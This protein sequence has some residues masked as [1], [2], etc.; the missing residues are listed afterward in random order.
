MDELKNLHLTEQSFRFNPQQLLASSVGLHPASQTG[1]AIVMRGAKSPIVE[2]TE[3]TPDDLPEQV[4]E[5]FACQATQQ[6]EWRP[7]PPRF[8]NAR[9]GDVV[10]APTSPTLIGE[11]LRALDPP[12]LHAH[13][14]IMTA[15]YT[16]VT[17]STAAPDRLLDYPQGS[18][19]GQPAP[20][21]GH[22]PDVL[23]YLWPGVI[24]QD[25]QTSIDGQ[26]LFDPEKPEKSYVIGGF[27][28]NQTKVDLGTLP[29]F[30]QP[31]VV[32][33]DPALETP[34]VRAK[35]HQAAD[36]AL[37]QTGKSHYRFY[38]YSNAAI[39]LT[40]KAPNSAGW[41]E[42]TFPSVCSSLVWMAIAKTGAK[43]EGAALESS[44]LATKPVRAIG[45]HDGLYV[46]R[47]EE[48]LVAGEL[49]YNLLYQMVIEK[50]LDSGAGALGGMLAD[51]AD[52]VANQILNTFASDHAETASKDS[53]AWRQ[54]QDASA[55]SPDN[56]LHWDGP[57]KQGLFGYFEPL[58]Y[59][60][61]RLELVTVHK[62]KKVATRGSISG[63]VTFNS[64]PVDKATVQVSEIKAT[65]T[66]PDGR[67]TLA[68]V[69][70]GDYLLKA[71]KPQPNGLYLSAQKNT[72]VIAGKTTT[73]N[74]QLTGPSDLYRQA[75]ID[76]TMA[77]MDYEWNAAAYPRS[78]EEFYR[79][80]RVGPYGTH[81]ET[82]VGDHADDV[83]GVAI[84]KAD[85]NPD[86][87]IKITLIGRY[88]DGSDEAGDL[89][90]ESKPHTF[91]VPA[92]ATVGKHLLIVDGALE[93]KYSADHV[94]IS[95]L[96]KNTRHPLRPS[97]H[98]PTGPWALNALLS[99]ASASGSRLP[100]LVPRH[101]GGKPD[102]ISL[103]RETA[104]TRR[105]GNRMPK[106]RKPK[107]EKAA[108]SNIPSATQV[109]P[110]QIEIN[111]PPIMSLLTWRS[112]L[113]DANKPG[114]AVVRPDDL[115]AL[116]IEVVNLAVVPGQPPLL[117]RASTGP[118]YIVLHFP[119][120]SIAEE[121]F[122]LTAPPS[123]GPP[124]VPEGAPA[125][126]DVNSASEKPN[127]PPIRARIADESRLVF[128]VPDD[129]AIPYTLA[130]VLAACERL[131]LN[132]PGNALAA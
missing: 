98:Q 93:D 3:C 1:S 89:E 47:A 36:W 55:V 131:A 39:G 122:F 110:A 60:P 105:R 104:V 24:T 19:L 12:Q 106:P 22:R 79:V 20:S 48:R 108:T 94:D 92:G 52:D 72:T 73:V 57:D 30:A 2:G 121:V 96:V 112:S 117:K 62:W 56:I 80:L 63:K 61:Q 76:I 27:D 23:K 26:E 83:Y 11:L 41:A 91:T 128:K 25:I 44:D 120:Q 59:R 84:V 100:L 13:S 97:G 74:L 50:V 34:A 43:M 124:S 113:F 5:G 38:G 68:D 69:Y 49:L 87:S 6:S 58:V 132:V 70:S 101:V 102:S 35:L 21:D 16:Q 9:K 81:A 114:K 15:N 129:F 32:K 67:Y 82:Q 64:Q 123:F 90:C 118:A 75:E 111:L 51:M 7:V 126:S 115:L 37:A 65:S 40:D 85:W 33:P 130:D 10:L 109:G 77:C 46:Y 99:I 86:K 88:Y 107:L 31:F 28:P 29:V 103:N 127:S 66:G 4:P 54:T 17:H 53:D 71:G 116:R 45:D 119:P 125:Q 18:I 8:L 42:G 14:G 78:H 95:I